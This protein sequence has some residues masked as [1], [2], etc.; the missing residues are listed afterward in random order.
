MWLVYLPHLNLLVPE[1]EYSRKQDALETFGYFMGDVA[2]LNVL[3]YLIGRIGGYFSKSPAQ[4]YK[5][6]LSCLAAGQKK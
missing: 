1:H 5:F 6:A 3:Q 4:I 2:Q